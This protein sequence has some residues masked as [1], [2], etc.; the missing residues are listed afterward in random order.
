[1][2]T[3]SLYGSHAFRRAFLE[4][5]VSSILGALGTP[6]TRYSFQKVQGLSAL[7]ASIRILPS[8]LVGVAFGLANGLFIDRLPAVYAAVISA[9]I[10]AIAPLLMAVVKPGAPYWYNAFWAQVSQATE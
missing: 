2:C 7:Q 1:M 3:H 9:V 6:L 8:V 4:L 10:C 5:V